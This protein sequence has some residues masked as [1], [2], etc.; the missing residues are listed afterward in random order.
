[1]EHGQGYVCLH[2]GY[3]FVEL[4]FTPAHHAFKLGLDKIVDVLSN[5]PTK[6]LKN[7]LGYCE[8]WAL[9]LQDHHDCEVRISADNGNT[10]KPTN[11]FQEYVV[12]PFLNQKMD[13]SGE[14]TQHGVIHASLEKLFAIIHSARN[15]S[16]TFNG[17]QMQELMLSLR[18]PL[19][20]MTTPRYASP[21]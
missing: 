3:T 7:F 4:L 9:T 11:I 21:S 15:D 18:G 5:V 20:S 13:F 17:K 14:K 19:V 2:I 16:A 6:D 10:T 1:M 12:F 8:A